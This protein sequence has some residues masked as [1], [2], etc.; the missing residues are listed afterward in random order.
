[1]TRAIFAFLLSFA[2]CTETIRLDHDPL[3]NLLELHI[4]PDSASVEIT[5][6]APPH[7]TLQYEAIGLF[8]DGSKRNLTNLVTWAIDRDALGAFDERGLFVASH[9]AAGHATVAARVRGLQATGALRVLVDATII[10]ATF[11]PPG[12]NLFAATKPVVTG[13]PTHTPELIYPSDGT[14]LPTLIA[15]TL[16]QLERGIG[17]DAFRISF[18]N[19]VLHLRVETGA[20]RW[21]ADGDIQR[22][23]ASSAGPDPLR[24]S[25]EATASMA[26]DP[27]YAGAP[28]AITF[29]ADMTDVPLY[30]WSSATNGIMRGGIDRTSASKLYPSSGTCVGCH[31]LSRNGTALA[32]GVDSGT[33]VTFQLETLDVVTQQPK[34]V[35]SPARPMGWAAYSPDGTRL[36]VAN[37]GVLTQYDANTGASL[38]TIPLPAMRFA[39]HPDWSPDGRSLAVALTA[40][41]PTNM[42]VRA[43]SIAVLTLTNGTWGA[44]QMLVTGSNT[45][46]NYFP[47]WS[48]DG[49]VIAY[50]HATTAS[51]GA[52]SA[53]LT[54][55]PATGGTPQPL[56]IANR[57]VG[58]T[59][60]AD[61]ANTMPTWGPRVGARLWLAFASAR[62][63]GKVV[64]GGPSQI[65]ITSLDPAAPGD[66][67]TPA[68]WL[69]CQDVT[70]LNNNPVWAGAEVT[71]L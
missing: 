64:T 39:T 50:V 1:M 13:D 71:T 59:D 15:S 62:P 11:P 40:Q 16:F 10:D 53:E 46:N 20:D 60:L 32:L 27:I 18:D 19:E 29:S 2:G 33:A 9:A 67:S 14:I 37:D 42:D 69:P 63:Y 47:R 24:V 54:L 49:S 17:N 55:I 43:A 70:V 44:P 38:G 34:I 6:L 30:Y 5:D 23:L 28:T 66:P 25:I 36:V 35:A 7:H 56:A 51:R 45:N 3:D 31:A 22:L 21:R 12:A 4:V 61:L 57:R 8:S 26:S 41:Q 68:F 58:A 48:P 52:A 65:W